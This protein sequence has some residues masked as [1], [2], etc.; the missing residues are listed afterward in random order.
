MAYEKKQRPAASTMPSPKS[1]TL[2]RQ[3]FM[4]PCA[5]GGGGGETR[6]APGRGAGAFL[7]FGFCCCFF[8][9]FFPTSCHSSS[10]PCCPSSGAGGSST[11]SPTAAAMACLRSSRD[12]SDGTCTEPLGPSSGESRPVKATVRLPPSAAPAPASSS[13]AF[14]SAATAGCA[15]R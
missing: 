1:S 8:F 13:S 4:S 14:S 5:L 11:S 12:A 2:G 9:F 3:L 6:M 15:G 10:S 7:S